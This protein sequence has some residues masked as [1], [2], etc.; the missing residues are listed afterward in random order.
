[1]KTC[2]SSSRSTALTTSQKAAHA[3]TS[4][5][6]PQPVDLNPKHDLVADIVMRD[7]ASRRNFTMTAKSQRQRKTGICKPRSMCT[8]PASKTSWR[9]FLEARQPVSRSSIPISLK[10]TVTMR[11]FERSFISLQGNNSIERRGAGT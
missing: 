1:M 4:D 11:H 8:P 7:S 3:R 10:S 2:R 6:N 9:P 5:I